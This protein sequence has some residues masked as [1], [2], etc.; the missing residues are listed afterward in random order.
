M[1]EPDAR[2]TGL[3]GELYKDVFLPLCD[4]LAP[5]HHSLACSPHRGLC[6]SGR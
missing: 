2:L 3:Y 1:L 5:V 6:S 4:A